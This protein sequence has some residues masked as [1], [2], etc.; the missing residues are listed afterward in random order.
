[1][2]AKFETYLRDADLYRLSDIL[3]SGALS[4]IDRSYETV[5]PLWRR[6]G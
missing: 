6:K 4:P 5:V 2:Q 1:M 3:S